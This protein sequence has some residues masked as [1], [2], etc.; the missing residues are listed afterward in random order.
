MYYK[1]KFVTTGRY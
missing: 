1:N